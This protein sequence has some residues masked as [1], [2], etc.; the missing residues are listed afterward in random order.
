MSVSES[1][2]RS[3]LSASLYSTTSVGSYADHDSSTLLFRESYLFPFFY[4]MFSLCHLPRLLFDLELVF[5]LLQGLGAGLWAT[6]DRIWV[7]GVSDS[8]GQRIFSLPID[9]GITWTYGGNAFGLSI[10]GIVVFVIYACWCVFLLWFYHL[11]HSY[12]SW[13]FYI[14]QFMFYVLLP[15]FIPP[16]FAIFSQIFVLLT[17]NQG[18]MEITLF[19]IYLII[20]TLMFLLF[21]YT[22]SFMSYSPVMSYTRLCSWDDRI[23]L[24]IVVSILI[25]SCSKL[26]EVFPVYFEVIAIFIYAAMFVRVSIQLCYYPFCILMTNITYFI[27]S[28]LMACY[29]VMNIPY[30]FAFPYYWQVPAVFTSAS[31]IVSL[32]LG[33]FYLYKR[34]K[35]LKS[36]LSIDDEQNEP[37][38]QMKREYFDSL[39]FSSIDELSAYLR[40]GLQFNC[41][42]FT[43]LSF[44]HYIIENYNEKD[45]VLRILQAVC[46]FPPQLQFFG[47]CLSALNKYDTLN[48]SE[49]FFQ[50]QIKKIFLLRQST[51]SNEASSRLHQLVKLEKESIEAIRGFWL[52]ITD[53]KKPVTLTAF[54]KLRKA[55]IHTK[56]QFLES[57]ARFTNNSH[58]CKHFSLYL[59]EGYGDFTSGIDWENT[60]TKIDQGKH[61]FVD[62]SFKSFVNMY[63]HYLTKKITDRNG[64]FKTKTKF[65]SHSESTSNTSTLSGSSNNMSSDTQSNSNLFFEDH[66]N[67]F[68][69]LRNPQSRIALQHS[70]KEARSHEITNFKGLL[71]VQTL[72]NIVLF[73]ILI[74]VMSSTMDDPKNI[75]QVLRQTSELGLSLSYTCMVCSF[76]LGKMLNIF[77]GYNDV[78]RILKIPSDIRFDMASLQNADDTIRLANNENKKLMQRLLTS[79][80]N[81]F[82]TSRDII[83]QFIDSKY[84][85]NVFANKNITTIN[86]KTSFRS[87]V[88]TLYQYLSN[89]ATYMHYDPTNQSQIDPLMTTT[90]NLIHT[91]EAI[92]NIKKEILSS[93]DKMTEQIKSVSIN[94]GVSIAVVY[95]VIFIPFNIVFIRRM[96]NAYKFIISKMKKVNPEIVQRSLQ[97]ISAKNRVS[98]LSDGSIYQTSQKDVFIITLVLAA[99]LF[100]FITSVLIFFI[101][102]IDM[103]YI[104]KVD[105]YFIWFSVSNSRYKHTIT[106]VSAALLY[107]CFDASVNDFHEVLI[108]SVQKLEEEQSQLLVG[109][110]N[111]SSMVSVNTILT[112]T[113]LVD[114]CGD[115]NVG[116]LQLLTCNSVD[117]S[118]EQLDYTLNKLSAT[119]KTTLI[120]ESIDFAQSIVIV[121]SHLRTDII[122]FQTAI[123]EFIDYNFDNDGYLQNIIAVIGIV[124]TLIFAI[125]EY[126]HIT[127]IQKGYAGIY[128]LI[129][130]LPPSDIV[131]SNELLSIIFGSSL[132]ENG[133]IMSPIQSLL[134]ATSNA[135]I[136]VSKDV[137]IENV[138]SA[139]L[140]MTGY[141]REQVLG[142]SLTSIFKAENTSSS[143]G[144]VDDGLNRLFIDIQM[145][146][147][148]MAEKHDIMTGKLTLENNHALSVKIV[149]IGLENEKDATCCDN[150]VLFIRDKTEENE[151]KKKVRHMKYQNDKLIEQII[152]PEVYRVIVTQ[153]GSTLFT[154]NSATVIFISVNGVDDHVNTLSPV[155]LMSYLAMVYDSFDISASKYITVHNI[156]AIDS[157]FISCCGLFDHE[158]EPRQ[159]V[160]EACRFCLECIDNILEINK[161]VGIEWSLKIGINYGGPLYGN[162]LDPSTPT[163]DIMGDIISF[164]MRAIRKGEKN[165]VHISEACADL[166]KEIPVEINHL[167]DM[168]SHGNVE[169]VF[170]FVKYSG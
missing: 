150:F 68:S 143:S 63:P 42:Y 8:V 157:L 77:D 102:Y 55:S 30:V 115:E 64:T 96:V 5:S 89:I 127:F 81:S 37:T 146:Q 135:V 71:L 79:L 26:L 19:A 164:A 114:T 38:D 39:H 147:Q 21:L 166:L 9:F 2:S 110:S 6:S 1:K 105:N 116:I 88:L 40:I 94:A 70:C 86:Y 49:Q 132:S 141:T 14:S 100:T 76:Q 145:M 121:D 125:I 18:T 95:I 32:S 22:N 156:K 119:L 10:A 58:I 117:R 29:Q 109:N 151:Q 123:R 155:D 154:S 90:Y 57:I 148:G 111:A 120:N 97:P 83:E 107:H 128:Q 165:I 87:Y 33:Y 25:P 36:K 31:I 45:V 27:L 84:I 101:L 122:K 136:S 170:R 149:L 82:D 48:L 137:T 47:Y 124:L 74:I 50:F 4:E 3:T 66:R 60:A 133:D 13:Q 93:W 104:T 80:I 65:V 73:I 99:F 51:V 7:P 54:N 69:I 144:T 118:I 169:K 67:A 113:H 140:S 160:L 126:Y 41:D 15:V 163:F 72:V 106:G 17:K 92:D 61:I 52:D 91:Y 43:D 46:Y 134:Y 44:P 20:I 35:K 28:T 23:Q 62:F 108:D 16:Y 103:E 11:N 12:K 153:S 158:S 130:L 142:Q 168:N 129:S 85:F 24:Y 152:P 162:V 138:N 139:F 75:L 161:N 34:A 131:K 78:V 159:Q 98:K 53:P 167:F 112:D 59:I 56:A